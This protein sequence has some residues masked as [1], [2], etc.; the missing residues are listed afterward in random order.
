TIPADATVTSVV[1]NVNGTDYTA[2]VDPAN[3]TWTIG[4]P[5]SQLVADTDLTV[6]AK[7]TF[8]DAAGNSSNLQ[9]TQSYTIASSSIIAYDNFDTAV[10]A[11]QP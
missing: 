9:A 1:V 7:A 10:L 6:D 2:V 8:T 3:G 4:V 11:P 5:G